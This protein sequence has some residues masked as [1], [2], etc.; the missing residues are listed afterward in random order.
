M[1]T[2]LFPSNKLQSHT[3][4]KD[5]TYIQKYVSYHTCQCQGVTEIDPE[6]GLAAATDP[7]KALTGSALV[8]MIGTLTG[9]KETDLGTGLVTDLVI[10]LGT[11]LVIGQGTGLV[12]GLMVDLVAD[13]VKGHV[14]ESGIAAA[15]AGEADPL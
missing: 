2:P 9:Q 14:T 10:G 3:I 11:C 7:R 8:P 5:K 1:R 15:V 12:I 13:L 4:T 6:V